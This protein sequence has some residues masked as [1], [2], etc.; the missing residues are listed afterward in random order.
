MKV[1]I[2][3]P[4]FIRGEDYYLIL[5]DFR[6]RNQTHEIFVF[7]ETY[8]RMGSKQPFR[9]SKD[10]PPGIITMDYVREYFEPTEV[11]L[12]EVPSVVA[13][14]NSDVCDE[15]NPII[16]GRTLDHGDDLCNRTFAQFYLLRKCYE[17]AMNWAKH[18][19][20]KFDMMIR[21]RFDV[22]WSIFDVDAESIAMTTD[23]PHVF[24]R[25]NYVIN[26][27]EPRKIEYF[28]DSFAFG[29]TKAIEKFSLLGDASKF[30]TVSKIANQ[31]FLDIK[32]K[33]TESDCRACHTN[34]VGETLLSVAFN[35]WE[36]KP[37]HH[38]THYKLQRTTF[39]DWKSR[40][41]GTPGYKNIK[42][43]TNPTSLVKMTPLS[44]TPYI[45][46]GVLIIVLI[47]C[48]LFLNR[49]G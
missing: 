10:T 24:F 25:G 17:I 33:S 38:H 11:H 44:Y 30:L 20:I 6:K 39:V 18:H 40:R 16:M 4:G 32:N 2:L 36:I 29:T 47:L 19:S 9:I 34:F 48:M 27:G 42:P 1:A 21:A 49:V 26:Q 45:L 41:E 37:V 3:L 35:L 12:N 15:V 43:I 13:K 5:K 28:N 7:I 8:D 46:G 31:Y 14:I 22:D 23:N